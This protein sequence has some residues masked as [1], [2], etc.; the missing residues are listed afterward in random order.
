A[1]H[2]LLD[3]P[4]RALDAEAAIYRHLIL[5][6]G[7]RPEGRT[8]L[9]VDRVSDL[10]TAED[11][12]LMPVEDATT[13]NGCVAATVVLDGAPVHVLD[14]GRLLLAEERRLLAEFTAA[15]AERA[16]RWDPA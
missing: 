5:L 14:L 16:E 13:F 7:L 11:G 6:D 12:A 9:L 4:Q 8:A 2:I 1:L 10:A 3:I 15:A